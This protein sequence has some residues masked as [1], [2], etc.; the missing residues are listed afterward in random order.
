M[1]YH[2]MFHHC[3]GIC[4]MKTRLLQVCLMV[5]YIHLWIIDPPHHLSFCVRVSLSLCVYA[6]VNKLETMQC[7]I[8]PSLPFCH[9]RQQGLTHWRSFFL[10]PS[11]LLSIVPF[12]RHKRW[13]ILMSTHKTLE[14]LTLL[15]F[16]VTKCLTTLSLSLFYSFILSVLL[17][18]ILLFAASLSLNLASSH[19]FTLNLPVVPLS[20]SLHTSQSVSLPLSLFPFSFNPDSYSPHNPKPL[21]HTHARWRWKAA[22]INH[23]DYDLYRPNINE[24]FEEWWHHSSVH[25]C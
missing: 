8:L 21:T 15:L 2:G 23:G 12:H 7:S 22:V 20:Y 9:Q 10:S 3:N 1:L 13:H 14:A 6:C 19:T 25:H 5:C 24:G 4:I 16:G 17:S 11:F 18:F